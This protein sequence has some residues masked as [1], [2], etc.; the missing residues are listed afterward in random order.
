[1]RRKKIS[2]LEQWFAGNTYK[3]TFCWINWEQKHTFVA[4]VFCI[5]IALFSFLEEHFFFFTQTIMKWLH[6]DAPTSA[7][8][9][10]SSNS[11]RKNELQLH[12]M[13][14]L[15]FFFVLF[16]FALFQSHSQKW[17]SHETRQWI[18][19][20]LFM[21][22]SYSF[23]W[24]WIKN[25]TMNSHMSQKGIDALRKRNIRKVQKN[26]DNLTFKGWF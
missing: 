2:D 7:L 22:E 5:K 19:T 11:W 10:L 21:N 24:N 9:K 3:D 8:I 16:G 4:E 25:W 14:I 1:M 6:S 23:N 13:E 12:K 18:G 15:F 17:F 20:L 26:G